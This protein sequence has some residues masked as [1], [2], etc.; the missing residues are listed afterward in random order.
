MIYVGVDFLHLHLLFV[1][2]QEAA[3]DR[4]LKIISDQKPSLMK[5][6]KV[7]RTTYGRNSR[8]RLPRAS[9]PRSFLYS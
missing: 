8:P 1:L 5:A 9:E 4:L 2:S 7:Q 3:A 6:G